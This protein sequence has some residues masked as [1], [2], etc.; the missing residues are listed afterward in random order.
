MTLPQPVR[1][2]GVPPL[3]RPLATT[4]A[5]M[6]GSALVVGA[7]TAMQPLLGLVCLLGV[8]LALAL[9]RRPHV[10]VYIIV[11]VAPVCAGLQRGLLVPGLRIS[12]AV[13][14]GLGLLVLVFA[15]RPE[16]PR[17]SGLELL[18]LLYAVATAVLGGL[19]LFERHAAL[20]TE[21]LGTLLGPFQFVILL[22]A[23][24]IALNEARYRVRAAQWMLVAASLLSLVALAQ[25]AD[26]GPTRAE[27][28]KLTASENYFSS[29]GVGVGRVTGPFN[30]WHELAGVLMPAVL[31][32]LALLLEA[33]GR[34]QKLFYGSVLFIT[35]MALL[36]TAVVGIMLVT[37][38]A[39]YAISWRKKVF[40]VAVLA[41]VPFAVVTIIVFG[42]I[43]GTRAEQQYSNSASSY[44]VPLVPESLTYRYAL[45]QEQ[46]APALSGHWETGYG[47]DL[48]P[49][50]ALGDFPFAE[51][52]YVSM[53]MRG[54]IPLLAIFLLL[55]LAAVRAARRALARAENEFQ[56][57]VAEVVLVVSAGYIVL[58]LIAS[59]MLDS[60]P[61]HSYWAFVGLM[62]A[63]YGR[64]GKDESPAQGIR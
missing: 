3:R 18:L 22:R 14:V 54:G 1:H 64:R 63:A 36:P 15:E 43:L 52:S 38:L 19:D 21:N 41:T 9:V 60:G 2:G 25:W 47:P 40:H 34:R 17:W 23:V 4:L 50:L 24:V 28:A 6:V 20:T 46:N 56:R 45:F 33:S 57:S 51:T 53:L 42:G 7:A 39:A 62:L 8:A 13:V 10:A 16:R 26:L 35:T 61:P 29:L 5:I 30:I 12:E 27:L 11:A 58:Q 37:L 32:S 31:L 48:P 59:Y 49:R 55:S 44:R